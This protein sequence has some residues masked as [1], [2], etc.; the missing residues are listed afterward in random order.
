MMSWICREWTKTE[1]GW[2]SDFE[3]FDSQH[4]ANECGKIHISL[5]KYDEIERDYEVYKIEN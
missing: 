1:E 5:K 4:E 2:T 3:T